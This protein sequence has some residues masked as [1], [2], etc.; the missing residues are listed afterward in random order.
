MLS[1]LSYEATTG[2]AR[3]ILSFTKL[4]ALFSLR[5][6]PDVRAYKH[7]ETSDNSLDLCISDHVAPVLMSTAFR[8]LLAD[9]GEGPSQSGCSSRKCQCMSHPVSGPK[10]LGRHYVVCQGISSSK[11]PKRS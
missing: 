7:A 2:T 6:D 9:V 11:W 3:E 10:D 5:D 8:A 1:P 4:S